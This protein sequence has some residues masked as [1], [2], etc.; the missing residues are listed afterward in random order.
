[1]QM[2]MQVS[3]EPVELVLMDWYV[4]QYAVSHNCR[5]AYGAEVFEVAVN[6]VMIVVT[7][8]QPLQ[9]RRL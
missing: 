7:H 2:T 8:Y 9:Q 4:G 6:R 1:M 5:T 3:P